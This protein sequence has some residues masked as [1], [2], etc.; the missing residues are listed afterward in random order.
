MSERRLGIDR[1]LRHLI[2]E[3]L[4]RLTTER[5]DNERRD[6]P[7]VSHRFWVYSDGEAAGLSQ[8]Y[9]GT[10]GLGGVTFWTPFPPSSPRVEIGLR[11]YSWPEEFKAIG[12]VVREM[13]DD[14]MVQVHV[15]FD[16]LPIAQELALA[17]YLARCVRAGL[18]AYFTGIVETPRSIAHAPSGE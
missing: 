1:R 9:E 17:R 18:T 6:S 14:G 15:T 10:L 4:A 13:R 5:R 7:R 11:I 16:E 2:P 12:H 3:P 8:V